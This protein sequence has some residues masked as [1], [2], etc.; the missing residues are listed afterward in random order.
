MFKSMKPVSK[1]IT[2]ANP[3]IDS[4]F[5]ST[6]PLLK[7]LLQS[8]GHTVRDT[9]HPGGCIGDAFVRST[10]QHGDIDPDLVI[11]FATD[12]IRTMQHNNVSDE[13]YWHNLIDKQLSS[14]DTIDEFH[15]WLGNNI[16]DEY[17]A[18][19]NFIEETYNNPLVLALGG[20]GKVDKTLLDKVTN[21]KHHVLLPSIMEWITDGVF[22]HTP[23]SFLSAGWPE[24]LKYESFNADIVNYIYE[25]TRHNPRLAF[26]ATNGYVECMLPDARHLNASG[27][28]KL[29]DLIQLWIE[30]N[31]S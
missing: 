5:P 28:T 11:W 23:I 1:F 26:L 20:T 15:N 14:F 25:K 9:V 31:V 4:P 18:I 22:V 17:V 27:A 19:H 29:F 10:E 30:E 16:N 21:S 3:V 13:V 24:H 6:I 12:T 7:L 2:D 8:A